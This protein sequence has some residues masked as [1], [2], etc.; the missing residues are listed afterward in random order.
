MFD[1][2]EKTAAHISTFETGLEM[3]GRA[4]AG[5]AL[6]ASLAEVTTHAEEMCV[7]AKGV[8]AIAV[9]Q[10]TGN[11]PSWTPH[12]YSPVSATSGPAAMNS[13]LYGSR[14]ASQTPSTC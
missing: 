9:L 14:V 10:T 7:A 11:L 4:V 5:V 8:A 12:E 13:L 2:S 3:A 1:L 6:V